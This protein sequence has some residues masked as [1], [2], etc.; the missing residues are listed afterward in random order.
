[1]RYLAETFPGA[2]LV[3]PTLRKSLKVVPVFRYA[4]TETL[5][6]CLAEAL[7]RDIGRSV[8]REG[9]LR[10][11]ASAVMFRF[12]QIHADNRLGVVFVFIRWRQA[13][14]LF[15]LVVPVRQPAQGSDVSF[16][17]VIRRAAS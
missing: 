3:F 9:L 8:S 16:S 7:S 11:S 4:T 14:P 13:W 17:G 15:P 12:H 10:S 6:P 5:K 1:M 2:I